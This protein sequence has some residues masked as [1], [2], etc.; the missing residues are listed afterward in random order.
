MAAPARFRITAWLIDC[1]WILAWAM[2]TASL[3]VPAYRAGW[4]QPA[5]M[6]GLN[7]IGAV[8]VVVPV[9]AAAA[10]F[11]SRAVSATPGKRLLNLVVL[12]PTGCPAFLAALLRNAVKIGLPWL[13]GHAAVFAIVATSSRGTGS[14][15]IWVWVL[16]GVAYAIPVL[17]L[18]SLFAAGGRTVYDRLSHTTVQRITIGFIQD[19][20]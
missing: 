8:V 6:I 11:E 16:T 12:S 13:I 9:V 10:W 7:L 19:D 3:G 17:Y 15:P 2:V 14:I 18:V 1:L 5:S 20:H 4:I